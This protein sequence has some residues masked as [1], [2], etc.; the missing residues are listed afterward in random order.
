MARTCN[1]E[2]D[3]VYLA[4]LTKAGLKPLSRWEK[5]L[6]P[7][8]HRLLRRLGLRTAT[9][10]RLLQNGGRTTELIFAR[11]ELPIRL[12]LHRFAGRPI[13]KSA[14]EQRVEGFLF[15]YPPC[16]VESFI[17]NGYQPN[18]LA[19]EEQR[20]FFHWACA[21]C[22]VTPLLV[23]HYRAVFEECQQEFRSQAET[24]RSWPRL[25]RLAAA[26][27]MVA[28]L[29]AGAL[30]RLFAQDAH[31]LPLASGLD[32]NGNY[33]LDRVEEGLLGLAP[34]TTASSLAR[35]VMQKIAALPQ[36]QT[37]GGIYIEHFPQYGLEKCSICGAD[38]NMGFVLISND[39]LKE[40]IT[41]PYMA[42]H[43]LEHGS[44]SFSG[45]LHQGRVHL[46]RLLRVLGLSD[47]VHVLQVE[48]SADGD[49]DGLVDAAEAR[50]SFSPQVAD[51]DS[52]GV[53]DGLEVSL[54]WAAEINALPSAC[55]CA[56]PGDRVYRI[57]HQAKGLE[58]CAICGELVNMGYVEIVNPMERFVVE[59]PYIALHYLEHGSFAYEGDVHGRGLEEPRTLDCVLHSPGGY[60]QQPVAGDAD[61]DGLQDDEEAGLG[62]NPTAR[63]TD[64]DGIP[65]GAALAWELHQAFQGL[66]TEPR[67]DGPYLR[68]YL[69]RGVEQCAVCGQWVNMGFARLVNPT[70]SDSLDVPYIAVH[71]LEHGA[72]TY[73]GSLHGA[74][75]LDPVRLAWLLG[76]QTAV[77]ENQS[78]LPRRS[79]LVAV[80]PN[81]F[82]SVTVLSYELS[83]PGVAELAIYNLLGQKVRTLASGWTQAGSYRVLWNGLD[84]GG[85]TLP[86]GLYLCCLRVGGRSQVSRVVF[87][88]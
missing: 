38:V 17:R 67:P 39:N 49:D 16:C 63:D 74:G 14:E 44:F 46:L 88:R 18:G 58:T 8:G 45:E 85:E 23:P 66:P 56:P 41:L 4:R 22:P 77:A 48:P 9:A 50:L 61:G 34:D 1:L 60:H 28:A 30:D 75:R 19:A 69:Q 40:A 47:R 7:Q 84:E 80:H 62:T 35:M 32:R 12:Y 54:D 43:Y 24:G 55:G 71:A 51:T 59:M 36:G 21:G 65:D 11:V 83:E 2:F 52:N 68:H 42:L 13:T 15:G 26:A 70:R 25:P 5:P 31:W 87:V 78:P 76:V 81:P 20:L 10:E 37:P 33:L 82:N 73:D 29:S 27:A 53:V 79:R 6:A 72:F 64:G 57:E 86:S 3:F